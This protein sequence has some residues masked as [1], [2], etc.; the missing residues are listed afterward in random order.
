MS[1]ERAERNLLLK[2][3][4]RKVSRSGLD[5][6]LVSGER[7]IFYL[8]SFFS[9]GAFLL[10]LKGGRP[11]YF[12]DDMNSALA[13][14]ELKGA[15][16]GD[17][18]AGPIKKTLK[19]VIGE[20]RI[21]KLGFN[22]KS[23][24]LSEYRS[25]TSKLGKVKFREASSILEDMR[26]K[27]RPFETALLRKAA[28]E[29]IKIWKE[30]RGKIRT[31]MSEKEVARLV[32]VTIR[33]KGHE[34]SF[35]TIAAI[36]KNSAFPHAI[37]TSR[38]LKKGEHILVDFGIRYSGYCSDLTRTWDNGRINGQIRDFRRSVRK[39][40]THAIERLK[41]GRAIGSLVKEAHKLLI[42]NNF[43][44][45][46]RHG[47]GHGIGLDVHEGP[48]LR[49]SSSERLKVGMVITVEPGLYKEGLGG[50]REEDMVL[51]TEK[52]CEVLTR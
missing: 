24:S 23:L 38:R 5:A 7:D 17:I 31:G 16:L 44:G 33:K 41:P 13:R 18:I 4:R 10:I 26:K 14:K 50:M 15:D 49:E 30:V 3:A 37:P 42:N 6:L 36:G 11:V 27:K 47:L 21:K 39:A 51:I 20:K 52:G 9:S 29:T 22:E 48:I 25:L 40:Q 45:Y 32:D 28:R 46:M 8:T 43:S 19:G 2:A 12:I 1:K 35:P 34:N